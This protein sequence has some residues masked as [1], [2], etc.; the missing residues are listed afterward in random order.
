MPG[1]LKKRKRAVHSAH[2]PHRATRIDKNDGKIDDL[3]IRRRA[4][5]IIGL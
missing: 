2:G 3:S 5:M 4:P 1:M